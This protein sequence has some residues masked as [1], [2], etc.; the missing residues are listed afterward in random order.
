MQKQLIFI[1]IILSI[2][3]FSFTQ[4][5]DKAEFQTDIKHI[6][7][8]EF[9]SQYGQGWQFSWNLNSTPHR[10][11]GGYISQH[12]NAAD[13]IE[14]EFAARDF[15]TA[16]QTL[17]N[18]HEANLD[19][20][21]NEQMGNIR[22]LIFNQVYQNVPV[23]NGR[24]DFRYRLN[25]DLVMTGNDA[26]SNLEVNVNPSINMAQCISFAK[27]HIGF[28]ENLNDEVIGDP[29][30]FIW[31][32]NSKEPV[33]HLAYKIELFVHSTDPQDDVPVHRWQVFVDAHNGNILDKFD[34]V[35]TANVEGHVTGGVKDQP[36]GM[37]MSRGM[38]HVKVNVTGVG[39]TY[40][41]ENGYYSIDIGNT[42]RSV[43]VKLEGSFLN[44][45]NANGSDASITRTVSP[46]TTEDFNFAAFNSIPGERDTYYQAN[47]VH[48]LAKSIHSG[49]T[50]ADYVMPAKV[51]IGPED[52]YW[53][54]NAYWDYNGIN[55]FS[56]G[57]G[58]AGTDQM[59]DVI[60]HEYGHGLQQ[61]IYD[62]Y[63]PNYSSSGLSEGCSDYWG[64][65]LTNSPCLGNGFFGEGS[66]LRDGN[67]TL[68][69]PANSCGGEVHCLGEYIMG[70]LWKMRENL[71]ELHGYDNGVAISDDLF[72]WAQTGRPS[73]DLDFLYEIY[74][75]DDN[76][77]NLQNG[78]LNYSQICNAFGD[79]NMSVSSLPECDD[80]FADLEFS[81]PS[82]D[83]NLAPG[84]SDSQAITISNVGEE[85][86]IMY[87]SSG[88]SPFSVVGDGPDN[89]GNFWSDSDL[90]TDINVE[91]VDIDGMG[92]LYTFPHNDEAGD[93]IN[94]G[95]DFPFQGG[96]Y[97]QCII[98][99][100]GWIGFG[101]DNTAWDNTSIP[102]YAAPGPAI[103][104]LWDDLNPENDQCTDNCSG[105]VYFYGDGEKFIVWFD[106]VVH[107]I[108]S[109][110]T[111]G[112]YD[113]QFVL[114]PNG[115]IDLNYNTLTGTHTATIGIQDGSGDNGMQVASDQAYLHDGLSIEFSQGP[116]WISVTPSTGEVNAGS[117]EVLSVV[118]D[119]TGLDDGLYEGYLRLVTSGGNAGLPVSMLVSGSP[120]L[121]GDINGDESVNIQDIIILINFILGTDDPDTGEFNAADIN[122]DGVLNIQ[123]II[124][125]VNLILD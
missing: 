10:I 95:F 91:W 37:E 105:D 42:S 59:A 120:S 13:P 61:F 124:L 25:G 56:E 21:V 12:F 19:L 18:I 93:Q 85:G 78:T 44:T 11:F 89:F 41:D 1:L 24:I 34:E 100:N 96:T 81:A 17:Y 83:F 58:C 77:G 107:W 123:D 101:S 33:Y 66:C 86:S 119:A 113:F 7:Q 70:A 109:G 31:V 122:S 15:I 99:A 79:H 97:S 50:G 20:W 106:Q 112:T 16:N 110:S 32:E 49:F 63:S 121:P 76:D 72:Y 74:I 26:Y 22:Y 94:I 60:Y 62:P 71:I 84:E 48:D 57:G 45:N 125:V 90:D 6:I 117:S 111:E 80:A 29:E 87:F 3:T 108:G 115:Q 114:Y 68:Q 38:P 9:E 118:A 67:N 102:S 2:S 4:Q 23:W 39:N 54:C 73:T 5:K 98:N 88:V 92:T 52:Y 104:G 64:M 28:D 82:L 36:Y 103:F 46:G 14:S 27:D 51:N 35:R 116:D 69:Y 75:S 55:L 30:M 53:P 40:T 47:I 8:G 43:T 65:T